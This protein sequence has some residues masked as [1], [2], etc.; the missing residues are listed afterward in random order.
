M[1]LQHP[2]R[3]QVDPETITDD[4]KPPQTGHTFNVW[5]LKWAGGDSNS[6]DLPLLR[7][8]VNIQQDS[9]YTKAT[10]GRTPLCLFFARGCCYKGKDCHYSHRIPRASDVVLPTQDCFGRD[11]T[12]DYNDDMSGVGLLQKSNRTLYVGGAHMNDQVQEELSKHFLEFGSIEYIKVLPSKGCAFISFRL[13]AEAQFAKEAMNQQSLD[14]KDVLSVKWANDDPNPTAQQLT[15]RHMEQVAMDTVRELLKDE[16]VN[17]NSKSK[18][19]S[20]R[21]R[22]PKPS[23]DEN[24]KTEYAL[25]L[26]ETPT[27]RLEG[28]TEGIFGSERLNAVKRLRLVGSPSLEAALL[29]AKKLGLGASENQP[30]CASLLG[31]YSSDELSD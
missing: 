6:R 12:S 19:P 29:L 1:S 15:K 26:G 5:Y 18:Y 16:P 10:D 21:P 20:K 31:E 9:G 22:S 4:D 28:A 8:R 23:D 25:S 30:T 24:S 14:G 27:S 13:E 17:A 3:L 7:F 11:K 2:A